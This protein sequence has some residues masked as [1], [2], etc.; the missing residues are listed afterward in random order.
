MIVVKV[1]ETTQTVHFS[2]LPNKASGYNNF[3]LAEQNLLNGF[4]QGQL[5][6]N[7]FSG[8]SI[9]LL[10]IFSI[11]AF[12]L[13]TICFAWTYRNLAPLRQS[14]FGFTLLSSYDPDDSV[15][16]QLLTSASLHTVDA[17]S[18]EESELF[19]MQTL[20]RQRSHIS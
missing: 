17:D 6:E 16:K 10:F 3:N 14:R 13:L 9:M 15:D 11:A 5:L 7:D 12:S 20:Q 8:F 4:G 2:L 19:N 18:D 1:N